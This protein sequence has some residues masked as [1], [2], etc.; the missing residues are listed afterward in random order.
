MDGYGRSLMNES[1]EQYIT[2]DY[3]KAY[4]NNENTI[5]HLLEFIDSMNHYEFPNLEYLTSFELVVP[6]VVEDKVLCKRIL[7]D[8]FLAPFLKLKKN[9]D[10]ISFKNLFFEYEVKSLMRVLNSME[11]YRVVLLTLLDWFF[12]VEKI[13]I[14]NEKDINERKAREAEMKRFKTYE[15][16]SMDDKNDYAAY[17]EHLFWDAVHEG[18]INPDNPLSF[19]TSFNEEIDYEPMSDYEYHR[20]SVKKAI[21]NF[22]EVFAEIVNVKGI[23]DEEKIRI[24]STINKI[25]NRFSLSIHIEGYIRKVKANQ[26][27]NQIINFLSEDL[28]RR[29]LTYETSGSHDIL[30]YHEQLEIFRI[31]FYH[32]LHDFNDDKNKDICIGYLTEQG[33][34]F[35]VSGVLKEITERIFNYLILRPLPED[36]WQQFINIVNNYSED[37][38]GDK[39]SKGEIV[40][41]N[42]RISLTFNTYSHNQS[43]FVFLTVY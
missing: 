21:K 31:P 22:D 32:P 14:Q 16:D 8:L 1:V 12:E 4:L 11:S 20:N 9:N 35:T 43:N 41:D 2:K 25:T 38:D 29:G 17:Q 33:K 5:E 36:F 19:S 40:M 42:G 34:H 18:E 30:I 10:I 7:S 39:K 24:L 37:E 6:K 27:A 13:E 28:Q 26:N 3:M 23:S 15:T